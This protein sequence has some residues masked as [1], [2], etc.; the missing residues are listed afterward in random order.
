M[1]SICFCGASLYLSL[2]R[3]SLPLFAGRISILIL[4]DTR[5]CVFAILGVWMVVKMCYGQSCFFFSIHL[6]HTVC[7]V[8]S[9]KEN[10]VALSI[11]IA[12][13]IYHTQNTHR[14]EYVTIL[15]SSV[16]KM[17]FVVVCLVK[18]NV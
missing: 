1:L 3:P 7:S 18:L 17:P 5:S 16:I 6:E 14:N 15:F 4:C 12:H 8:L 2:S 10:L 11:A 9:T 13:I